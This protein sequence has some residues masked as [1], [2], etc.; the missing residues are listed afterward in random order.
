MCILTK[1]CT[2]T[3][4]CT[5]MGESRLLED[6]AHY[7]DWTTGRQYKGELFEEDEKNIGLN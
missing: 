5:D 3:L 2:R 1:I 7:S 4:L 6:Y